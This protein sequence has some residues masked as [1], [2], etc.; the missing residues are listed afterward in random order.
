MITAEEVARSIHQPRGPAA[1]EV[2]PA[3]LLGCPI[4]RRNRQ[5]TVNCD[6]SRNT[7]NAS[8]IV[9][10]LLT[11]NMSQIARAL[12]DG[13]NCAQ[14]PAE[15][16]ASGIRKLNCLARDPNGPINSIEKQRD[17]K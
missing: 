11:R 6:K 8:D 12:S 2:S 15:R 5:V 14:C 1:C 3:G 13:F 7:I 16:I 17:E 4:L 9:V 10:S